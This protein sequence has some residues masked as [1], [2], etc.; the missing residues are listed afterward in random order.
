VLTDVEQ[1][2]AGTLGLGDEGVLGDLD[3]QAFCWHV[4]LA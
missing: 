1:D 4:G 2:G 3:D